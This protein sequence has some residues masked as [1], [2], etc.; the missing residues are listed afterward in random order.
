[1][2]TT[3][4]TKNPRPPVGRRPRGNDSPL[5]Q[6]DSTDAEDDGCGGSVRNQDHLDVS[7]AGNLAT[8]DCAQ[9]HHAGFAAR[10]HPGRDELGRRTFS[11]IT[12]RRVSKVKV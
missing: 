1:M 11:R 10:S 5:T 3:L 6:G 7:G 12:D 8:G 4:L 9:G 2:T